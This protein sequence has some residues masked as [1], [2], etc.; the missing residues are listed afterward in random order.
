MYWQPLNESQWYVKII[1]S[2][3]RR[4]PWG[5]FIPE[6]RWWPADKRFCVNFASLIFRLNIILFYTLRRCRSHVISETLFW[7]DTQHQ[8]K[9]IAASS[10]IV[11][12]L[13]LWYK[14]SARIRLKSCG[15]IVTS[16][17]VTASKMRENATKF[18]FEWSSPLFDTSIL[19]IRFRN[20][21]LIL[22]RTLRLFYT[23][24]KSLHHYVAWRRVL[25][26]AFHVTG[27]CKE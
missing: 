6:F 3:I 17:A 9:N 23:G 14:L 24:Q 20:L 12:R 26:V 25:V 16:T 11:C 5:V 19:F 1:L 21:V 18:V 4:I 22:K 10:I 13:L 15:D 2:P 7:G 27:G 8:V